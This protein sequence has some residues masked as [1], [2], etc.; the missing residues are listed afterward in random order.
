MGGDSDKEL[1]DREKSIVKSMAQMLYKFSRAQWTLV[2][3]DDMVK[4]V[5]NKTFL[6]RTTLAAVS[7]NA[8]SLLSY[9]IIFD[10]SCISLKQIYSCANILFHKSVSS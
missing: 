5:N 2:N 9:Y 8:Q 3:I 1:C 10:C 7:D 6:H 4:D